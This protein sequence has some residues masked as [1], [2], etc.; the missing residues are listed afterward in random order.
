MALHGREDVVFVDLRDPRELEREGR[1]PGAVHCPR[2]MLEFWIDPESPYHKPVFAQ[3]KTF[4]FFCAGGLALGSFR[5]HRPGHGPAAGRPYRRR[6]HRLEECR[7]GCRDGRAEEGLRCS[8]DFEPRRQVDSRFA[9]VEDLDILDQ[10]A[11]R[12]LMAC[13]QHHLDKIRRTGKHDLDRAIPSI[14]HPAPEAMQFRHMLCPGAK[15]YALDA[16]MDQDMEGSV[17]GCHQIWI[18]R[19][20]LPD[21]PYAASCLPGDWDEPTPSRPTRNLLSQGRNES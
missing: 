2:G 11:G 9:A 19:F 1:I 12:S 3:D 10:G 4:V 18:M 17:L 6:V 20:A 16:T 15:A 21:P 8:P 14:P 5:S 7:R 13:F